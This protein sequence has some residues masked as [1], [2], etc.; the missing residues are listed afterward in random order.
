MATTAGAV[1]TAGTPPPPAAEVIHPYTFDAG[2]AAWIRN[3]NQGQHGGGGLAMAAAP[4]EVESSFSAAAVAAFDGAV[5]AHVGGPPDQ[6]AVNA[7][8]VNDESSVDE[9]GDDGVD[10]D[11]PALDQVDGGAHVGGPPDQV[12]ANAG[13]VNVD[14]RARVMRHALRNAWAPGG[15]FRR[16][17]ERNWVDPAMTRRGMAM[18]WKPGGVYRFEVERYERSLP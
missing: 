4:L 14:A 5:A 9:D 15:V 1:Q 13:V 2:I 6:V 3:Q 12:A 11:A 17:A 7:G 16:L 8:V 10:D 18:A